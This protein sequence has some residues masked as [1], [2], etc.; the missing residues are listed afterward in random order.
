MRML[1]PLRAWKVT[2]SSISAFSP[3]II[4]EPSSARIEVRCP[5]TLL[6]PTRTSPTIRAN[7][8]ICTFS[9]KVGPTGSGFQEVFGAALTPVI[10]S[11]PPSS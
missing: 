9:P 6:L 1:V 8:S 3:M 4:G 11:N 10:A 5:I 2:R 7:S